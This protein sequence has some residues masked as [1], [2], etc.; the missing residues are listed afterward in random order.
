MTSEMTLLRA[1]EHM[2][3]HGYSCFPTYDLW[4]VAALI[5]AVVPWEV[6]EKSGSNRS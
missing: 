4:F 5:V 1:Q 6:G 2:S 3:E